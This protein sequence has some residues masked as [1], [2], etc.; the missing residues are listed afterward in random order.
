M[1]KY[2]LGN[3]STL[4][5]KWPFL[6]CAIFKTLIECMSAM[7]ELHGKEAFLDMMTELCDMV[8]DEDIRSEY[9]AT[10]KK[11]V[12]MEVNGRHAE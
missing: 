4:I 12:Q 3:G 11:A 8:T 2:E 6:T 10:V 5:D 7:V 1:K 9:R